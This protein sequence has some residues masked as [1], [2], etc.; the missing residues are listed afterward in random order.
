M[1]F[2]QSSLAL[3]TTVDRRGSRWQTKVMLV[4]QIE[5][6]FFPIKFECDFC[7]DDD[8]RQNRLLYPLLCMC[9]RGKILAFIST[10][11]VC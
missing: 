11:G 2:D 4:D 3:M 10:F 6:Y 7:T 8:D 1:P 9:L 5:A